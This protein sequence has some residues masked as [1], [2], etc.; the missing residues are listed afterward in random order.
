MWRYRERASEV[1]HHQFVTEWQHIDP[2]HQH[3]WSTGLCRKRPTP[4]KLRDQ[5]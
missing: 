2:R 3:L 1:W 5:H 4:P